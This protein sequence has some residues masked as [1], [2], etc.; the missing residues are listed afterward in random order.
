MSKRFY[1]DAR[2]QYFKAAVDHLNGSLGFYEFDGLVPAAPQH[3][4]RAGL[5]RGESDPRP[6]GRRRTSGYFDFDSKGPEFF[7]RIAF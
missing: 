2:A 3:L 1:L 4:V 5:H 6:R 7:V